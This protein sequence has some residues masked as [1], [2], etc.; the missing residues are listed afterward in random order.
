MYGF[1]YTNLTPWNYLSLSSTQKGFSI[2]GPVKFNGLQYIDYEVGIYNNAS[3][4]AME[5][6]NTKPMPT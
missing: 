4:H 1:R 3:F 6:T 2:Q 5:F